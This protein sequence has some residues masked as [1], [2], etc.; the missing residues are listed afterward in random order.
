[1]PRK[2]K[3]SRTKKATQPKSDPYQEVTDNIIKALEGGTAPWVCP[4]D[5]T[6][7]LPRNGHSGHIYNGINVM[8]TWGAGYADA[9][10]YTFNQVKK[11]YGGSHVRRGEKSTPV[12]KW[13]FL[14][15]DEKDD[16]GN[17]T[18]KTK[19]IPRLRVYRVFNHEQ[20]EWAEG[21]EPQLPEGNDFDPEAACVE[22]ATLLSEAGCELKHGGARACYSDSTD[23]V[24]LPPARL[25]ESPEAYWATALHEAAHWTGHKSRCNRDMTGRFGSESYAAEELVA[26]L[27]AAFLCADLGIQGKLQHPSYIAN[28]LK[29]LRDDKYAIFTAARHAREAV[30]F[31]KGE[32]PSKKA[33]APKADEPTNENLAEAA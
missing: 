23:E 16:N 10:F 1:M 15:V 27:G 30:A 4:W 28:W 20:I 22:A 25:F 29:V 8:L 13:L 18:G 2:T 31:L 24:R 26:E 9:R 17:P 12:I 7:G 11:N 21:Q 19:T 14:K 6:A 3:T 32:A 5:R 33:G